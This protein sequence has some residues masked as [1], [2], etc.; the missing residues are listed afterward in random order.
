[1]ETSSSLAQFLQEAS[2]SI[3]AVAAL[4]YVVYI[5]IKFIN[6]QAT[7]HGAAMRE[8]EEALRE[9]EKEIRHTL[10]EHIVQ[11]NVAL[12]ENSRALERSAEVNRNIL[13]LIKR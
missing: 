2:F 3:V 11:S 13:E 5:F 12:T 1:M 6:D 4:V 7:T 8:R 9:V 10:T